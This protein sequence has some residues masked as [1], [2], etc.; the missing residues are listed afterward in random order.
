MV[1]GT[2]ISLEVYFADSW[3]YVSLRG[4]SYGKNVHMVNISYYNY[5]SCFHC[6]YRWLNAN[7]V[8]KCTNEKKGY[9]QVQV[10]LTPSSY[11]A[12]SLQSVP[13]VVDYK[14]HSPGH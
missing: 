13:K 14:L 9:D 4:F 7:P 8:V 5:G 1:L 6:M 3:I 10:I 2:N 11:K 12:P